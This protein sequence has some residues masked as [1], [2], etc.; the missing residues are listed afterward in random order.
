M[1]RKK[2]E[3]KMKKTL[4]VIG[5][6]IVIC[7]LLFAA[8]GNKEDGKITDRANDTTKMSTTSKV[9]EAATEVKDK[10]KEAVT[11][12]GDKV[13]E[14]AKDV[15]D[16]A[17]EILTGAADGVKDAVTGAGEMVSDVVS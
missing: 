1:T 3:D 2:G 12:A 10:V 11:D 6:L 14:A 15:G 13:G 17:G 8:C 9:K 4:L 7:A 16:E 5:S